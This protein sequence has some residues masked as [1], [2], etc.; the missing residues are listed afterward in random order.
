MR[1]TF[2]TLGAS[3][4]QK[5]DFFH[6]ICRVVIDNIR[7]KRVRVKRR[8]LAIVLLMLSISGA[9]SP[10]YAATAEDFRTPEYLRN[11]AAL[12]SIHAADAYALGYSGAGVTVGI[13]NRVGDLSSN[14]EFNGKVDSGSHWISD[15]S[16]ASPHGYW[17]A[18]V[19]GAARNGVGVQGI[20]YD[21]NLL[22]LGTD[23]SIGDLLQGMV[24]MTNRPDVKIIS[25]SWGFLFYPDQLSS[26][27]AAMQDLLLNTVV[28]A[29]VSAGNVLASQGQLMVMSAGNEGHLTPTLFSALPTVLDN[30]GL[31]DNIANT[32]INVM[33]YDPSQP[34]SSAAF[35]ATFSNLAQGATEYSLL[36]PGVNII[37][38]STNNTYFRVS[39]TSFASP[40]VAGVGALV[41]QAF[42]YMSGKQIA[43]VLLST[44]TPLT[45]D[46]LP[47]AVVLANEQYDENQSLTGTAIKVYS[48]H[49]GITFTDDELT[50]LISSL[51]I[52]SPY[53][54]M[55]DDQV[56]AAILSAAADQNITVMSQSDYQALFGQGVV[57]AFKAVQ[58]PGLLNAKRLVDSD[59][60]SGTFGGN[61]ALYSIDTKGI[62]S[63]WSNDIGQVKNTTS[64]SALLGLDVGLRKQGAGTL[65]L[66]GNDT[67]A[68]PTVVEGGKL[69]VGK[70]AGDAGHLAGDAWV[71]SGAILGGHG[72]INGS[73][74]VQNGGTLSPG[75]SIGTLTVGN[76]RFDP[77]SIYLVEIDQQGNADQLVVTN[78]AQLA[79]TVKLVGQAPAHLGAQFT[80]V[81]AG[82]LTGA[83]DALESTNNSLF[84]T[85]ALTYN[86]QSALVSVVRN[87]VRFSDVAQTANQ[88]AIA[89]AIDNQSGTAV[90]SAIAD[91]PDADSARRAFDNLNGE[92]YASARNAL[93]Q[94]SQSV[95]EILNNTM[96]SAGK[97]VEPWV[98]SW[99]YDG[100][101]DSNGVQA[102]I[103]YNGY[104]VL[105]GNGTPVGE[106]GALGV[107]VGAEKGQITMDSRAS[108][109]D[110]NALHAGVYLSGRALALDLRSGL[111][112][113]HITLDSQR[114]ITVLS[115]DGQATGDYRANLAQGFVEASHRFDFFDNV[116]V[117]PYGN[118][119]WVWLQN[120]AGQEGGNSAALAFD[121][122]T[123]RSAFATGGLR[124][125][126]RP[127]SRLPVS[128]YGDIGYQHRLTHDDNQVRLRFVSGGD[129]FTTQGLPL[130]DNTR[131]M[132]AGVAVDFSRNMHLSLGYQGDRATRMKDDSAQAL[133][134]MA[135]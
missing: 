45:G 25:N 22:T 29:Y 76:V 92:F 132:R 128:L 49:T 100:R 46:A 10:G 37:T 20:A 99:G 55:T 122:E 134:S 84:L 103:K 74:V 102:G 34:T 50:T 73:V 16:S 13:I 24:D 27:S 70:V 53:N 64:G 104:G 82:T 12:D 39:G 107:A 38:P 120:Q 86:A 58:G 126:V 1:M 2:Q 114:G 118:T 51:K 6:H 97:G 124:L 94:N 59:L 131:L 80:L 123:S 42:P 110:L 112:Y 91:L 35:I 119:A 61:F 68:G 19:I 14:D 26:Y 7:V 89:N 78:T 108:R 52:K 23:N 54:G 47:K 87:S 129:T 72:T 28:P 4:A 127:L 83:F 9:V 30:N 40:Y 95:R 96:S 36:A 111:S 33:A 48:T 135:F 21:S 3:H 105:L 115:L 65:Y 98:S 8:C 17:V 133:F 121:K 44:A 5:T 18:G 60:S 69:I 57:N 71:L 11:G 62:D 32:W 125:K 90:L 56:R 109:G 43:D 101:Q 77:G 93:I 66:T 88:S 63:T 85:N 15:P 117:E 113:S 31:Q 75:N 116:S 67:F 41:S 81:K 130:A 79:G 106:Q